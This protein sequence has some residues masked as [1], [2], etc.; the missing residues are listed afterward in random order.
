MEVSQPSILLLASA[1]QMKKWVGDGVAWNGMGVLLA[2][3]L[4][5]VYLKP[6]V[7]NVFICDVL[8]LHW[9]RVSPLPVRGLQYRTEIVHSLGR[10]KHGKLQEERFL[11]FSK[12]GGYA[13]QLSFFHSL[14][15]S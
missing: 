12:V 6:Q 4:V 14:P 7:K 10:L 3:A 1:I 11:E 13:V 9:K 15:A 8:V 5:L 2:S